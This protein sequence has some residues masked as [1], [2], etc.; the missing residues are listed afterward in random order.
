MNSQTSLGLDLASR[1]LLQNYREGKITLNEIDLE[2][3]GN[4]GFLYHLLSDDID[5]FLLLP[6][7]LRKDRNVTKLALD[8]GAE[9]CMIDE[10][11][12][13]DK[14]IILES[15][16]NSGFQANLQEF[17]MLCLALHADEELVKQAIIRD[18]STFKH[19]NKELKN[20]LHFLVEIVSEIPEVFQFFSEDV[21]KLEKAIFAFMGPRGQ[22]VAFLQWAPQEILHNREI[23]LHAVSIDPELFAILPSELKRDPEFLRCYHSNSL[24]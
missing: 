2:F 21:R 10:A 24:S 17:K 5:R 4:V 19:I 7:A 9:L 1:D 20:N 23:M 12:F 11:F 8:L 14:E 16:K 22:N 3:L 15:I 6:M 13:C 18:P